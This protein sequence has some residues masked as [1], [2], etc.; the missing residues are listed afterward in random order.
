MFRVRELSC[1]EEEQDEASSVP[2]EK[3]AFEARDKV[4]K[5]GTRGSRAF[6]I[7]VV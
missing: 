1:R 3:A 4:A 2:R 6:K 7:S 5:G